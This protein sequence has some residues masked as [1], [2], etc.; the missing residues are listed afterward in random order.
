MPKDLS[1]STVWSGHFRINVKFDFA[2]FLISPDFWFR[3][4]KNLTPKS[5]KRVFLDY[6][7]KIFWRPKSNPVLYITVKSTSENWIL[8]S[9]YFGGLNQKSDMISICEIYFTLIPRIPNQLIENWRRSRLFSDCNWGKLGK[10]DMAILV[11][12]KVFSCLKW[13]I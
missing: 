8:G 11:F 5:K 4:P 3:P 10:W 2:G 1:I 12:F 13:P 6:G 9:K 7:V